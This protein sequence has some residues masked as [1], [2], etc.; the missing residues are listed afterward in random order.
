MNAAWH[1]THRMPASPTVEQRMAWHIEHARECACREIPPKLLAE[2]KKRGLV[3]D[4]KSLNP[5]K[6]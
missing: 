4:V 3:K 5:R 1:K 6:R 2:M